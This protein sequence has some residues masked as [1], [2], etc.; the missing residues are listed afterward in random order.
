MKRR[1]IGSF[2]LGLLGAIANIV[3][4]FYFFLVYVFASA[5]AEGPI[6]PMIISI[7]LM[8]AALVLALVACVFSFFKARISGILFSVSAG[9]ILGLSI[10]FLALSGD[11]LTVGI[12]SASGI[13]YVIALIFAFLAKPQE[14]EQGE[15]DVFKLKEIK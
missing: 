12:Y 8:A 15:Q 7:I 10:Y 5:F 1:S 6:I 13:F 3:A 14:C 2:V 4:L 11:A 9:F